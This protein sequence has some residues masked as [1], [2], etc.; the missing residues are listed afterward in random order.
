M[1]ALI[2]V[3]MALAAWGVSVEVR[4]SGTASGTDIARM[5]ERASNNEKRLGSH[6]HVEFERLARVDER[7]T[8]ITEQMRTVE[9]KVDEV[10]AFILRGSAR[11]DGAGNGPR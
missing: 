8:V 6:H 4:I 5:Q 3:A 9:G 10:L 11:R 2:P 7:L 1:L